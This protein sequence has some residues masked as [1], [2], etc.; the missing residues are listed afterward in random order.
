MIRIAVFC[1]GSGTNLQA[2]LDACAAGTI[3]GTVALVVSDRKDAY[4]LA[5]AEAAGVETLY[6]DPRGFA[7]KE[8]YE[9]KVI[10]ALDGHRIDLIC[11]AGYMRVLSPFFIRR[12]K[13]KILNIHPALL[14]AFKGGHAIADA[15]AFGAKVTGVTVHFATEELDNG[16]IILQEA[17]IIKE[18]DT[19]ETLLER[20]HAVEHRLYP[21]AVQLIARGRLKVEGRKVHIAS[22][23]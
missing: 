16:P 21:Q 4:A 20:V 13:H 7:G 1:S 15:L 19:P 6:I 17:V 10:A 2:L 9:E 5:R 11:L 8:A 23:E 14:P 22:S 18:G 3:D 12:Y